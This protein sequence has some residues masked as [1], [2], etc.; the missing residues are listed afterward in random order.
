MSEEKKEYTFGGLEEFSLEE[1]E[2]EVLNDDMYLDVFAG[3]DLR[4]KEGI[5]DL[6]SNIIDQIKTLS[7]ISFNYKADF[8]EKSDERNLGLIAQEVA[9]IFPEAVGKDKNGTLYVNYSSLVPVLF[10]SIKQLSNQVENC[11]AEINKLKNKIE[12]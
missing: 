3:S 1:I 4:I 12:Q 5:K 11:T 7:C 8:C 10:E 2:K 6:P 9:A